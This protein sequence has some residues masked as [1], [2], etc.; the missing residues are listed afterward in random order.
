MKSET[1]P[2]RTIPVGG[3]RQA[4][5]ASFRDLAPLIE[6]D[7]ALWATTGIS[8]SSLR[9][10]PG[11]LK[12]IDADDN[13][14]IRSDEVREALRFLTANLADGSG[15]DAASPE[16]RLDAI[17]PASKA[18]LDAAKTVLSDLGR[19][20]AGAITAADIA[21]SAKL[22]SG[23]SGKGNGAVDPDPGSEAEAAA[24]AADIKAATGASAA[25]PAEIDAFTAD[26]RSW[27]EWLRRPE[28]DPAILPF[29]GDTAAA[30]AATA[31]VAPAFD[32]YFLNVAARRFLDADPERFARKELTADI[33]DAAEL[34]A[35]LGRIAVAAPG[36]DDALD[37]AAP[38]NPLWKERVA[39]FAAL[40]AV[41]KECEDGRLSA[42]A[43]Q[44]I[45]QALAPYDAWQAAKPANGWFAA[46]SA[47]E[48]AAKL[49]APGLK[50][51][52]ELSDADLAE[53]KMLAARDD[54]AKL[55]SFQQYILEF[56]CNFVNLSRLFT[57]GRVSALQLG[58]LVIDGRIYSLTTPVPNLAE[59]KKIAATS[60][61]CV[62]YVEV[63]AAPGGG[64]KRLLAAAITAGSMRNLFVGKCGI[65]F[66]ADG[67]VCDARIVDFI[68][69]P[70]SIAEALKEPFYRFG[71]FVGKQADRFFAAKSAAGE[72]EFGDKLNQGL[73]ATSSAKPAAAPPPAP[74]GASLP[75]L[76]AGGGIGIAAISSAVAFIAKS[77]ENI[78][79][80]KLAAV[81]LGII[82]IFG[83]PLVVIALIKLASR[84][85]S[86][87][88][89]ASG[90]AINP[91]IRMTRRT[92]RIFTVTPRFGDG[93]ERSGAWKWLSAILCVVA[94]IAVAVW[95][96]LRFVCGVC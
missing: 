83:G 47:D 21:E 51:L 28:N 7:D 70:V 72:K 75:M 3:A 42:A 31:A 10:D 90:C 45:R 71:R 96:W 77:L 1:T 79:A 88:L 85:L 76:L 39:A 80:W 82:A 67:T 78:S 11:F 60:N 93:E 33:L 55:V 27:V 36:A 30:A 2:I 65:F 54:L 24:A 15:V 53:A 22:R 86:R 32:D 44:K 4:A 57:P 94:G 68:E 17:A 26:A 18:L 89:E 50:R 9:L 58:R 8:V 56:L 95:I 87:F 23:S 92:G 48:I 62:A 40:P 69:Q 91:R 73:A 81:I 5:A 29:G 43:W 52:R 38:I 34:R 66:D 37:F 20:D 13:G 41:R 16:L 19:P 74:A 59:H 84:S 6:L 61:I 25:G 64:G 46:F 14:R 35:A 63:T 49:E 12:F